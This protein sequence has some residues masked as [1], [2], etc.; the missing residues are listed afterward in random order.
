MRELSELNIN[1]GGTPVQRP[2]PTEEEIANFQK[3]FS[4]SLPLEYLMLLKHSNGGHPELCSFIPKFQ[5][6]S[7]RWGI[8]YFYH[9]N[10]E[11]DNILNLWKVTENWQ[12]I[13]GKT[14]IPIA[15]DGGGNQI[16]L[17]TK[18]NPPSVYLCIH[19]QQFKKIYVADS[20]SEFIDLLSIDPD[21]I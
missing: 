9:L 11:Y 2:A 20:F 18:D 5:D 17:D 1:E 3:H 8:D 15:S 10:S 21:M 14:A 13:L 4:V 19:D 7:N 6:E 16:F 12:P